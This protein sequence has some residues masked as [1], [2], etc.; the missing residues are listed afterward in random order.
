[1]LWHDP[2]DLSREFRPIGWHNR[3]R[4]RGATQSAG[5]DKYL[6]QNEGNITILMSEKGMLSPKDGIVS[7]AFSFPRR[8]RLARRLMHSHD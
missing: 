6:L 3:Y 4:R 5:W 2:V 7:S 8:G 1:M